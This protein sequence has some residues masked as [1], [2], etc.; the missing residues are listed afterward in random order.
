MATIIQ[1]AA[2]SGDARALVLA[3]WMRER[4]L[5]IARCDLRA[6]ARAEHYLA[7]LQS[8]IAAIAYDAACGPTVAP[9]SH[10]VTMAAE[11]V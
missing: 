4:E 10:A 6:L 8:E 5:A 7:C 1:Q 11:A 3:R 9:V 2:D